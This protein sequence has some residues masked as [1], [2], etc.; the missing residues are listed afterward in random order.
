MRSSSPVIAAY[1]APLQGMDAREVKDPAAPN[2]LYNIDLS[3]DGIWKE[4]PGISLFKDVTDS[5]AGGHGGTGKI[6]GLHATRIDGRF[7]LF[8]VSAKTST[9]EMFFFVL[10]NAGNYITPPGNITESGT[11]G[12]PYTDKHYYSFM[13]ASRFVYFCNGYG[14]FYEVEVGLARPEPK[15]AVLETGLYN[16]IM[17]YV[18]GNLAPTSMTY[19]YDQ[20]VLCGFRTGVS[21][22]ISNPIDDQNKSIVPPEELIDGGR[23]SLTVDPGTTLVSEPALWRS[24]PVEDPSGFYWIFNESVVGSAGI[25]LSLLLFSNKSLYRIDGHGSQSPQRIWVSDVSI[26]GPKAWVKFNNFIFFVALDGCYITD[27]QAVNKVSYEMD[28]LWFGREEPQTTRHVE[29]QIQKTPYPFHVNHYATENTICINDRTREQ[30]M[31]CLPSSD[32]QDNNMVWVFNYSS[33]ADGSGK[34]K[35]SIWGGSEEPT[36]AGTSLDG[37]PFTAGGT[38]NDPATSP[39]VSNSG[40]LS[41]LWHWTAATDDVF[42]GR[43]QIFAGT[44]EGGVFIFGDATIDL[45]TVNTYDVDGDRVGDAAREVPFPALISLG[46]VGRVDAEGRIICTDVV[47][48]RKQLIKNNEDNTNATKMVATVRS[49][50][51]GMKHFDASEVDVEFSD[52]IDNMQDGVSEDAKYMLNDFKLGASPTGDSVPLMESEYIESYARVNTPDEE[53]RAAYVDIYGLPTAE[54]HRWH[55]SEVRVLGNVKGGSQRE[56]S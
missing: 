55:I 25:G 49:E 33:I 11:V 36:Y 51:E 19:F 31:I 16:L 21:V 10:D 30:I 56:Q 17:S 53:G 5:G 8:G 38:R 43:Q 20:I 7:M 24:Y 41:R 9:S 27:G 4:R 23:T 37:L 46:R 44:D 48:R 26:V 54:P 14:N 22:P 32:A 13:T 45:A 18:E 29:Q 39:T 34:G 50:G 15:H 6:M 35:W 3:H 52:T 28:P 2:L 12:E 40:T 1:Q 42:E 47:V